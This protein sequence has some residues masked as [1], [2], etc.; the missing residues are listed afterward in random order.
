MNDHLF[1]IGAQRSGTTY[2]R[3]VL[4]AHPGVFMA[5]SVNAEPKY[6]LDVGSAVDDYSVYWKKY[7]LEAENIKWL[8]EKSTSYLE[9]EDAARNIK[10]KIP[11]AKI[12][13]ILR[14]PVERAISN[15]CFSRENGIEPYGIEKALSEEPARIDTWPSEQFSVSPYAYTDRGKYMQH[16]EFWEHNF[17]KDNLIVLASERFIGNQAEV[18]SL[19]E[20]LGLDSGFIPTCLDERVNA[21]ASG[22]AGFS[23]P[24]SLRDTLK[25]TFKPWNRKLAEHFGLDVSCWSGMS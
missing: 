23:M 20:K 2:L 1:I 25:E 18:A 3:N 19:Y 17:S 24:N 4:D 22:R 7:F 9:R 8:G 11:D 12:L 6:F 21:G 10:S 13:V 16:L 14:D 15:Y 5:R